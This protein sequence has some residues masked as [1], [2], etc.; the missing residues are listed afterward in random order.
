LRRREQRKSK[1]GK[2]LVEKQKAPQ[3]AVEHRSLKYL[4]AVARHKWRL[5]A[6]AFLVVAVLLVIGIVQ[7]SRT[8]N[9]AK[10]YDAHFEAETAKQ[11]RAVHNEYPKT[12][13]GSVSLLEAGKLLHRDGKYAEARKA[14]LQFL[15]TGRAPRLRAAAYNL[16]GATFEAEEK[17]DRAIEYYRR[18]ETDATAKF[19]AKLNIGR[20]YELK[21]DSEE[22]PEKAL[23]HYELARTYY[24]QLAKET[25]ASPTA[26]P[27]TTP[28]QGPAE[29]RT[30]FLAEKE[31]KARERQS[32]KKVDKATP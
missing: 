25:P 24:R 31:R 18:A 15:E 19:Q 28:W 11:Y 9:E 8:R 4:T 12:F 10:A 29:E 2:T 27:V 30:T 7:H 6:L 14:F 26:S 32:Q 16:L 17:Y 1:K 5:A 21:G 3:E 22:D 20:C 13:H 23:E